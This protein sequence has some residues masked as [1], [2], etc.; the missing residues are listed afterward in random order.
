M[1][2]S[3][4]VKS[5]YAR[6][7]VILL[8]ANATWAAEAHVVPITELHA[9]TVSASEGRQTNLAKL[10]QFF[11]TDAISRALR[12]A[13]LDGAQVP[14]AVGVLSNEELARLASQADRSPS[15]LSARALT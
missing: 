1:C 13:T 9:K 2:V 14:Q 8:P 7:L 15:D 10:D 3:S 6:I 4:I 5:F 12:S 11:S